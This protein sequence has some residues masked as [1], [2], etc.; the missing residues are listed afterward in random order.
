MDFSSLLVKGKTP[1]V[2]QK[3]LQGTSDGESDGS[4]MMFTMDLLSTLSSELAQPVFNLG[5]IFSP[6]GRFPLL[7]SMAP[8]TPRSRLAT[9]KSYTFPAR[10]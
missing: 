5:P 10:T 3:T 7:A 2:N 6:S 9:G 4:G 8:C 1:Q